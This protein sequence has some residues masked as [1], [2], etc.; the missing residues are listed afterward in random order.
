MSI[1]LINSYIIVKPAPRRSSSEI[2]SLYTYSFY[3]DN[4]DIKLEYISAKRILSNAILPTYSNLLLRIHLIKYTLGHC[5]QTT[6]NYFQSSLES[7]SRL[8]SSDCIIYIFMLKQ[9]ILFSIL[10]K[11]KH[12]FQSSNT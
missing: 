1:N 7:K 11:E 6:I 3:H 10:I 2:P 5:P 9:N 4:K 12:A 8:F